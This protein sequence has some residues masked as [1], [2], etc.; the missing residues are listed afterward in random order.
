[1]VIQVQQKGHKVGVNLFQKLFFWSSR[2]KRSEITKQCKCRCS[3]F[4]VLLRVSRHISTCNYTELL[5]WTTKHE[6]HLHPFEWSCHFLFLSTPCINSLF[7][8]HALIVQTVWYCSQRTHHTK[9]IFLITFQVSQVSR[10][11]LNYCFPFS[12]PVQ[13]LR[14]AKALHIFLLPSNKSFPDVLS[15]LFPSNSASYD[16]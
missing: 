1:M 9:T 7:H 5:K 3:D 11:P 13:P 6:Q 16:D 8:L 4:S 10:L 12:E 15:V 2:S 14:Q